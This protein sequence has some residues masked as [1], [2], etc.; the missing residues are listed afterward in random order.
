VFLED[1]DYVYE[2]DII[3]TDESGSGMIRFNDNSILEIGNSSEVDLRLLIFSS[4]RARLNVGILQGAARFI[5]GGIV[6][7][8]PRFLKLTTPKS[9][10]GIRGTT[11][12]IEENSDSEAI[13]GEDLE[14]GH[15]IIVT[16]NRT[17][18]IC[19]IRGNGGSVHTDGKDTMTVSGVAQR[20]ITYP[21]VVA[22]RNSLR[23]TTGNGER[24]GG[25][26]RDSGNTVSGHRN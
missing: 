2:F 10:I 17:F 15:Y 25:G 14:E 1:G 23:R 3:Q 9:A 6:K 16:N 13:T 22:I 7:I 19:S 8:N 5:S 12:L 21:S 18:E 4:A 11:L 24:E 26:C 20:G